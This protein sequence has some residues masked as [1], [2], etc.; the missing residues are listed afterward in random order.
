MKNKNSVS[1]RL[2]LSALSILVLA[3]F[4][5]V[6]LVAFSSMNKSTAWFASSGNVSA[7]G[8]SVSANNPEEIHVT[9]TSYAISDISGTTYTL[10]NEQSVGTYTS[11]Q[12]TD[13]GTANKTVAIHNATEG[14]AYFVGS[15]EHGKISNQPSISNT[16]ILKET[17]AFNDEDVVV[18]RGNTSTAREVAFNDSTD[19]NYKKDLEYRNIYYRKDADGN[20]VANKFSKIDPDGAP[21][22]SKL[23]GLKTYPTNTIWFKPENSGECAIA[24]FRPD[25]GSSNV[26]SIYRY[27]RKTDGTMLADSLQEIVLNMEKSASAGSSFANGAILCFTLKIDLSELTAGS[28]QEGVIPGYEYAIGRSTATDGIEKPAPA[29]FIYLKLAGTDRTQ[30]NIPEGNAPDNLP[31]RI[32]EKIDFVKSFDAPDAT[33]DY[34]SQMVQRKSRFM[35]SGAHNGTASAG[36]YFDVVDVTETDG[37]VVEKILYLNTSALEMTQQFTVNAPVKE[38]TKESEFTPRSS[39]KQSTS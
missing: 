10:A 9:V 23:T 15:L 14:S 32:L 22:F 37:S 36:I 16:W 33:K 30:G 5:V 3:T 34:W 24:F 31:Y 26:M 18:V 27:L 17:L 29:G 25:K 39:P 19:P 20:D 13:Y 7:S 6:S 35:I 12:I 2:M 21:L 38:A 1:T 28:D 8:I 11:T 4:L